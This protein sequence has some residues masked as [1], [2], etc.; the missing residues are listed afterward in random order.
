MRAVAFKEQGIFGALKMFAGGL[1][2]FTAMPAQGVDLEAQ[3]RAKGV[4][5]STHFS[6]FVELKDAFDRGADLALP[7]F[8]WVGLGVAGHFLV[9][10]AQFVPRAES[11]SSGEDGLFGGEGRSEGAFGERGDLF[12]VLGLK[13]EDVHLFELHGIGIGGAFECA[14]GFG[15]ECGSAHLIGGLFDLEQGVPIFGVALEGL[16]EEFF[17]LVVVFAGLLCG[18]TCPHR[19][20]LAALCVPSEDAVSDGEGGPDIGCWGGRWGVASAII[21]VSSI[22]RVARGRRLEE[23]D[24]SPAAFEGT[25]RAS[26][27]AIGELEHVRRAGVSV[28]DEGLDVFVGGGEVLFFGEVFDEP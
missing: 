21:E 15:G 20:F 4:D 5:K 28:L 6:G 16:F 3:N 13:K 24:G 8:L 17:G 1:V 10:A 23:M 19:P 9:R 2:A 18:I 14:A 26:E 25:A 7:L 27:E 12:F 22:R 11:P